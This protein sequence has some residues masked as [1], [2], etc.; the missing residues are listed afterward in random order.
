MI[1]LLT[2]KI[3][4]LVIAMIYYTWREILANQLR[5]RADMNER[6]AYMLWV[7]ANRS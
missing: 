5:H 2:C 7:A 4:L 1:P 3:S 6:I